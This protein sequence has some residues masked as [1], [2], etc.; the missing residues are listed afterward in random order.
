MRDLSEKIMEI[1]ILT[2]VA[3]GTAWFIYGL[4]QLVDVLF[5][6]NKIC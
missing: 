3:C 4:Y 2:I 1:I 5:I 6:R